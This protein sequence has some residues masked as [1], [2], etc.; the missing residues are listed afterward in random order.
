MNPRG[1][2]LPVL[3]IAGAA[4]GAATLFATSERLAP[5][6]PEPIAPAVRVL[7][8]AL[9]PVQMVVH[10]QGTVLPRTESQLVPEVSGNVVW[11]SPNLVVGG[12][13]DTGE[14]LLR[15][16]DRDYANA[17]ERARANIS[18]AEAELEYAEFELARLETLETDDLISRSAVEAAMREARVNEAALRDARVALEQAE[19]DLARTE[20]SAPFRGFVRSEQ[21]DVGQFVNRGTAIATIYAVDYVEVRLPIA[22]Q[23]LAY[24]DLPVTPRGELDSE[25]APMVRLSA[26]FAGQR[27]Q[28]L[29]RLVRTEA[30]IDAR[31]RMVQAVARI[32]AT[33]EGEPPPV[34]LFVQAEIE[35]RSAD[36]IMILPR[37]AIRNNDQVLIVDADDRLRFRTVG[38]ARV[39]GDDAFVN[40]GLKPGERICISPLQAVVEGMRVD[41]ISAD[42]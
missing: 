6:Q 11:I 18:R 14:P 3:V 32:S 8:V 12:Y 33:D 38:L 27:R 22:D 17:V 20:V 39:Y 35:G 42:D 24:L 31:D 30:E 7:D 19:R 40:S 29:G 34:G 5:S 2:L 10:A 16:D 36:D 13:F 28:W 21:I 41:P 1:K 26:N 23:Q 37:N 25:S 4:L 9:A 15:V